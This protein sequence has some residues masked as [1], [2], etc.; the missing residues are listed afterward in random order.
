MWGCMGGKQ[1]GKCHG[2]GRVG[3]GEGE[4]LT[5]GSGRGYNREEGGR[6]ERGAGVGG[7]VGRLEVQ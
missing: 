1:V 4:L 7:V 2:H 5:D 3:V 6:R